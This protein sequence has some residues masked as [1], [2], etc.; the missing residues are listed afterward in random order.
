MLNPELK[1]NTKLFDQDVEQ[2]PIRQGFGDGLLEAGEKNPQM[3]QIS[4]DRTTSRMLNS[5]G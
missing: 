1:L 4:T 2:I 5:D 3:T